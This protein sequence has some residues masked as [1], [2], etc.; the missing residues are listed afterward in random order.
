MLSGNSS[1]FTL[2]NG[3]AG[4]PAPAVIRFFVCRCPRV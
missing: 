1:Q 2:L 4:G 3:T